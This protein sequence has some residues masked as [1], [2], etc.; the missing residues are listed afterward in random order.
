[1]WG[2]GT[3]KL[4][5]NAGSYYGRMYE[6]MYLAGISGSM[7]KTDKIAFTPALPSSQVII[8]SNASAKEMIVRPD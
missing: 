8:A 3:E 6:G 5:K 1:M 2:G 7:T 4:A